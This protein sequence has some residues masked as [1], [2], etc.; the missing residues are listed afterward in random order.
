MATHRKCDIT[1]WIVERKLLLDRYSRIIYDETGLLRGVLCSLEPYTNR[2]TFKT[3]KVKRLQR[4]RK[5]LVEI[6]V[7]RKS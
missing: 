4:V 2:L 7:R 1:A 3:K 6:R 5:I